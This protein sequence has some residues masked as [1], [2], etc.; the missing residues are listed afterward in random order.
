MR[1]TPYR[2][3]ARLL[4]RGGN[5]VEA[6]G[7]G[8]VDLSGAAEH[9]IARRQDVLRILVVPLEPR[10]VGAIDGAAPPQ[11]KR[12][13]SNIN[14]RAWDTTHPQT[15]TGQNPHIHIHTPKA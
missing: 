5:R 11:S 4:A 9:R 6:Q 15:R 14:V 2:A 8:H 7:D 3:N 13:A 10:Q 1:Q 12:W